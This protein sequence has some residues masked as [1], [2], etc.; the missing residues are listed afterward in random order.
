MK[1][2]ASFWTYLGGIRWRFRFVKSSQIPNDRWA[3]CSDPGDPKRQIRVREVLRGRAK[4]ETVLHE[5]LHAQWP[6]DSEE[7]IK[8]S[9]K[10]LAD[11]LWKIGYRKIED[12]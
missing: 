8:K 7:K 9:G 1:P 5:A 10:E 6:E 11:L 3:D 2:F 12:G 4:L